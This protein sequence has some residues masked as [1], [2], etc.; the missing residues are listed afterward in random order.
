[1]Y[2]RLIS[3]VLSLFFSHLCFIQLLLIEVCLILV[4]QVSRVSLFPLLR[5]VLHLF[6][7]LILLILILSFV[8]LQFG[9]LFE[10]GLAPLDFLLLFLIV[11][12][13]FLVR[14]LL[15]ILHGQIIALIR[16][17][18]S[19]LFLPVLF[20][21]DFICGKSTLD[22]LSLVLV[23]DVLGVIHLL[24]VA[25]GGVLGFCRLLSFLLDHLWVLHLL[26]GRVFP[27]LLL[28]L[29]PLL[30]LPVLLA[31]LELLGHFEE[32][33]RTGGIRLA[34]LVLLVV[35]VLLLVLWAL[36]LLLV[37]HCSVLLPL[38]IGLILAILFLVV[39]VLVLLARY[40]LIV[41]HGLIRLLQ[42]FLGLIFLV[43]LVHV[44]ILVLLVI[45]LIVFL[46][47]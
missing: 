8:L 4:D 16:G 39:L 43:R 46:E 12:C 23:M 9:S 47:L 15:V 33:V 14:I 45:S 37:R 13:F 28:F 29:L 34:D 20:I 17:F 40:L 35:L 32:E 19:M 5:R 1:M 36:L 38:E 27:L 6:I 22:L 7:F 31:L 21:L 24:I 30:L 3:V 10:L 2:I 42:D 18:I 11:T 25:L 26:L 44:L 41:K